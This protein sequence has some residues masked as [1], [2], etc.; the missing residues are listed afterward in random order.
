MDAHDDDDGRTVDSGSRR[1]FLAA[2]GAAAA[3]SLAGC[4]GV[5]TG[6]SDDGD[7]GSVGLSDFRGSGPMVEQRGEPDG[8]SIDEL[9]DLSG[10]LTVYLGGGEGGLYLTL[11]ELLEQE[12]ADFEV[13][14]QRNSSSDLANTIIE[15]SKAGA[16]QA[17][18]FLAVD[19]GSL[20]TV[21]REGAA[22]SLSDDVLE[23]VPDAFQDGEGRWV[24]FAGRARAVPY[25]TNELS[26]EDVPSSIQEFPE[27]DALA[28]AMGWGPSYGA[29][30]SM[31]TAMRLS[32]GDEATRSWLEAMLDAG[33]TQYSNEWEVSNAVAD[34][35]LNAGFANHYY[36][37]RVQRDRPDAPIDLAFTEND[38]G[39]LV[40]VSGAQLLDGSEN[41]DLAE[42]F[43]R[44]LLSAEAQEFFATRTFAYP[45]IPGVEPVG[46]LP[47]IDELN[48]P[49]IDLTE[50]ADVSGTVDMLRDVGAL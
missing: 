40:N 16:V 30:Q 47:T 3:S 10:S 38:A 44:H 15:E 7:S 35:E 9:P 4:S 48:P 34:G 37:L 6:S 26:A 18:A 41:V 36:A 50:L 22:A 21:A 45:M 29:F 32:R 19:A 17:D 1:R 5:L 42:N 13:Q 33:V 39:A 8:T 25:N 27:S 28:D 2:S 31:V 24:G 14:H 23:P 11:I 46:G 43:F 20:G 12:Y 49:D